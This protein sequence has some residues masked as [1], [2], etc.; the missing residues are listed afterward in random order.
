MRDRTSLNLSGHLRIIARRNGAVVLDVMEPNLV[1]DGSAEIVCRALGGATTINYIGIGNGSAPPNV[2]QTGLSGDGFNAEITAVSYPE[3]G[4]VRF[5]AH[6]AEEDANDLGGITEFV[7]FSGDLA[8]YSRRVRS[9]AVPK[10]NEIELDI[11][12]TL[13]ITSTD[14]GA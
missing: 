7:L 4:Q 5:V 12:W 11:E 13:A 10:T 1:L 2:S 6:V 14:Q 3:A 8:A 9:P